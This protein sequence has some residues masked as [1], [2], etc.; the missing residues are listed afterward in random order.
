[1]SSPAI[2][3]ISLIFGAALAIA[4]LFRPFMGMLLLVVIHFVQPGELI[5]ALDP[6]RI[7]LVYGILV[8]VSLIVHRISRSPAPLFSDRIFLGA[9]I[10]LGAAFLS[11][12]FAVW[13]GGAAST[14]I[15]L[16]KLIALIALLSILV[17]TQARLRTLLW[18]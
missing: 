3:G 15:E 13:R 10:L 6:F 8:I 9:L 12:P 7:E 18:C 17:D 11:I 5:P 2:L 1:M 4:G 14:A 16:A